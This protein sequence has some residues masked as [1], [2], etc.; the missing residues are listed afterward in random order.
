MIAL[1]KSGYSAAV[2]IRLIV[3]DAAYDVAQVAGDVF[4][5]RD[6][7]EVAPGTMAKLVVTIDDECFI[8]HIQLRDGIAP[9]QRVV[10]GFW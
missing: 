10:R 4:F 8:N 1:E 6:S 9:G 5:L 3:D 2:D 7:C